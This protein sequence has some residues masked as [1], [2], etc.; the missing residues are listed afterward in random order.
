MPTHARIKVSSRDGK[1]VEQLFQRIPNLDFSDLWVALAMDP[2]SSN[3]G[4]LLTYHGLLALHLF[5]DGTNCDN[6][7]VRAGPAKG[8]S[9]LDL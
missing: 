4:S 8:A 9:S 6:G 2:C 5:T 7:A 1:E 3:S